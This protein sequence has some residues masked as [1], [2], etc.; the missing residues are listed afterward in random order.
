[1][2]YSRVDLGAD[3][4]R[5]NVFVNTIAPLA[6]TRMTETVM[7]PDLVAALKPEFV[8]PLVLYLTH[9]SSKVNGQVFEGMLARVLSITCLLTFA[10]SW[11]RLGLSGSLAA[12]QGP[13][14]PSGYEALHSR[15]RRFCNFSNRQ[16]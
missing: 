14:L 13:I 10:G 12:Q 11:S 6:G 16:L 7:P 2:F 9:E 3:S 5:R 4:C 1:M 15:G 8:A